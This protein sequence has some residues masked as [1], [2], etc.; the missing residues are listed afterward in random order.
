MFY[1]AMVP[2]QR[3]DRKLNQGRLW[4]AGATSALPLSHD[5]RTTTNPHNPLY[6]LHMWY[7]MPQSHTWQPL[8][9]SGV[10]RAQP[11]PGHSMGTLCLRAASYPGP[12]KLLRLQCGN[13]E[14]TRGVWG[15]VANVKNQPPNFKQLIPCAWR[16]HWCLNNRTLKL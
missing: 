2:R 10:A 15:R 4:L 11:M 1:P 16:A 3:M 7:W 14:A 13:E 6:V 5:S 12:A 8:S 9:I